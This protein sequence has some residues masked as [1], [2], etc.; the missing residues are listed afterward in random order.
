MDY[1]K[2]LGISRDSSESDIKTA[3]RT[4]AK[5]HHPDRG[6]DADLF[7]EIGEA[8]SVLSDAQ[9]KSN[10]DRHGSAKPRQGG[11]FDMNDIFNGF[12]MNDIFG[13]FNQNSRGYGTRQRVGATIH[14]NVGV[15]IGEVLVGCTKT[16][17]YQRGEECSS[18]VG[19]GG[20]G[21]KQCMSC[22]G[23]GQQV[24]RLMTPMGVVEVMTECLS[25]GGDGH[26]VETPCV[27]CGGNGVKSMEHVFDVNIPAGVATGMLMEIPLKGSYVKNGLY[28]NLRIQIDEV[29]DEHVIRDGN[30]VLIKANINITTAVLGGDV[31]VKTPH[32]NMSIRV[33]PGT[34]GGHHYEYSNMGIPNL[35]PNGQCFGSGDMIIIAEV[36]IPTL[37][38]DEQK[39][40]FIKL[41][42]IENDK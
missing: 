27:S 36:I 30:D 34:Q 11:G 10:Y 1:Y 7:K 19:A 32:G 38:T 8:Y 24:Q 21:L 29:L 41:S 31:V 33:E 37:I 14:I 2:V 13:G 12:D 6:G 42:E 39:E 9:S 40:L 35:Q 5:E 22:N 15:D 17:K 23:S 20:V 28:G 16:V 25:C 26:V 18:C 4:K 3:Y